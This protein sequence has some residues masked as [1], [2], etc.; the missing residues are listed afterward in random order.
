MLSLGQLL[1]LVHVGLQA[2]THTVGSA[3]LQ[4]TM[5]DGDV[6]TL[7]RTTRDG[8]TAGTSGGR[9]E[10]SNIGRVSRAH[11]DELDALPELLVGGPDAQEGVHGAAALAP[12]GKPVDQHD[13]LSLIQGLHLAPVVLLRVHLNPQLVLG[14]P[15]AAAGRDTGGGSRCAD[16]GPTRA[17]AAWGRTFRHQDTAAG[18]HGAHG[19]QRTAFAALPAPDVA[20]NA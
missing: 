1:E 12:G 14:L 10:A 4:G 5:E 16:E 8:D 6:A 13:V 11:L 15:P 7:H 19:R 2:K 20:G 3:T 9:E 17:E 18:P